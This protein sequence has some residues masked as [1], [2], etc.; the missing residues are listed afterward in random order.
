MAPEPDGIAHCDIEIAV[1]E[2]SDEVVQKVIFTLEEIGAPKGSWL[3]FS[4]GQDSIAFGRSEGMG[5]F[6]NG[7][8]LPDEVYAN[9]DVNDVIERCEKRMD[10]A[11][12]FRGHREGSRETALYFYGD[13]LE[14][15]Q[16][17]TADLIATE[18]LCEKA[19]VLQ[20]A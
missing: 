9:S 14:M 20:I 6:L 8:D 5:L 3:N 16:S 17:A 10:G 2:A 18:P 7:T 15:M 1:K 13:S 12:Q 19:R 11:G 4:E